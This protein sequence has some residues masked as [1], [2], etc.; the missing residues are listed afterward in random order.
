VHFDDR[1]PNRIEARCGAS[2]CEGKKYH[3]QATHTFLDRLIRQ[4]R[5]GEAARPRLGQAKVDAIAVTGRR[6]PD[7]SR[8]IVRTLAWG[9]VGGVKVYF[10]EG[11]S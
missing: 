3:E 1:R 5:E 8:D 9:P 7:P 11:S 2:Q 6:Q 10:C 4:N